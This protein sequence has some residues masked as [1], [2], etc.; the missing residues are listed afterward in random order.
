MSDGKD[1]IFDPAYK[2][3][4]LHLDAD[5]Q[6]APAVKVEVDPMMMKVA[7]AVVSGGSGRHMRFGG[8]SKED[9]LAMQIRKSEQAMEKQKVVQKKLK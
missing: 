3:P 4:K 2:P 9:K 6:L 1:E 5:G 8:A 7:E